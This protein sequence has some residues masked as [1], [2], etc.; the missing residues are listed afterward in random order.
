WWKDEDQAL[1][2]NWN[3]KNAQALSF[4][5][6][7][8]SPQ[9]LLPFQ[10][11]TKAKKV[12]DDLKDR[13][14]VFDAARRVELFEEFTR[15]GWEGNE[16]PVSFFTRLR[17]AVQLCAESGRIVAAE[18]QTFYALRAIKKPEYSVLKET[19]KHSAGLTLNKIEK[20]IVDKFQE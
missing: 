18:E 11:Y 20:A 8:M 4:L 14:Q 17:G 16:D 6:Q 10:G 5:W 15:I 19:L 12:W 2:N 3:R 9:Q 13:F 1:F 7:V